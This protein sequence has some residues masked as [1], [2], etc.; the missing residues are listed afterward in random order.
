MILI[1]NNKTK[2]VVGAYPSQ[3]KVVYMIP[4]MNC[5]PRN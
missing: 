1:I 4:T 2:V 3:E 5:Y